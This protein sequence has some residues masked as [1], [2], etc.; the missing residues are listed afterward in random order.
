[1]EGWL[2]RPHTIRTSLESVPEVERWRKLEDVLYD[3]SVRLADA[4][5]HIEDGAYSDDPESQEYMDESESESLHSELQSPVPS[6]RK[7]ETAI[8]RQ[9]LKKPRSLD[10]K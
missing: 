4:E 7:S 5:R 10:P 8:T 2:L 9:H 3:L 1:M 6:E